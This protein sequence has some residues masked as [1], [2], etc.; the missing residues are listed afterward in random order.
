MIFSIYNCISILILSFIIVPLGCSSNSISSASTDISII[1]SLVDDFRRT[2]LPATADSSFILR[3]NRFL[4]MPED[5]FDNLISNIYPNRT[6]SGNETHFNDGVISNVRLISRITIAG[7]PGLGFNGI[8]ENLI[9]GLRQLLEET[10]YCRFGIGKTPANTYIYRK[11]GISIMF[12]YNDYHHE[13][14]I[15]LHE[16]NEN[17]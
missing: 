5:T 9:K 3:L 11:D 12:W 14:S 7:K 6:I 1:T 17:E 15:K 13:W 8:H 10:G 4:N 2:S 16:Y